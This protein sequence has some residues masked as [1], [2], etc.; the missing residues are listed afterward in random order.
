MSRFIRFLSRRGGR[1]AQRAGTGADQSGA[2]AGKQRSK[3]ALPCNIQL[4]DGTDLVVDL[5]VSS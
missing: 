3:H 4:L 5:P 1:A 2:G